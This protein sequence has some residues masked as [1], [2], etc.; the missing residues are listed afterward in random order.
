MQITIEQVKRIAL[1][2]MRQGIRDG[3]LIACAE[4]RSSAIAE[5]LLRESPVK[6]NEPQWWVVTQG[7]Y[8]ML[9]AQAF[10][11]DRQKAVD[12]AEID[13]WTVWAIVHE[14]DWKGAKYNRIDKAPKIV[15]R[16]A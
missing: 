8:R 7:P 11:Q 15:R 16:A 2:A 3:N 5:T 13:P 9:T 4:E 12:F 10:G 1:E 14:V 6:S